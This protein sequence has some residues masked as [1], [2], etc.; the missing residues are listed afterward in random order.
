MQASLITPV[1]A[2]LGLIIHLLFG[3]Q[4]SEGQLNTITDGLVAISLLIVAVVTFL[5]AKPK[6]DK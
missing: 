2:F 6:K 1:V 5:K 3:V 4:L